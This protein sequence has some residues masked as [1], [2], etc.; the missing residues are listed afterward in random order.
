MC[1]EKYCIALIGDYYSDDEDCAVLEN[2][3][4]TVLMNDDVIR[5]N[6][7]SGE[8]IQQVK[9]DLF[10]CGFGFYQA[11]DG[12]IIY[13]EIEIMMLDHELKKKWSF[14]G[15]DIFVSITGK[16]PFQMFEDHISLYDFNDHYYEIDYNGVLIKE[17]K[18]GGCDA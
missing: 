9:T 14:S 1:S 13:G 17:L 6:V 8:L 12:Y 5:I 18:S 7:S 11:K 16:N 10:G 4:L 3:I 2:E 15:C